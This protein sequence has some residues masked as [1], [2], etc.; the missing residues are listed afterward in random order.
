MRVRATE[1]GYYDN[2]LRPEGSEFDL[3]PG[4]R[5]DKQ[6]RKEVAVP[7]RE[8]FSSVWME[9]V[10]VEAPTENEADEGGEE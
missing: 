8:Q 1:K 4:K 5:F 3:L 9:E 6:K 7:V 10:K 2:R